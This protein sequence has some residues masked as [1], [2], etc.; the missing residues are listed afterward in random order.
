MPQL[1]V[2][3]R[4][5]RVESLH[6]GYICVSDPDRNIVY[7]IGSPDI[8]CFLRSAGKPIYAVALVDSGAMEKFGLT[9]RDLAMFCSS[10]QG[11]AYQRRIILSI[12]KKIGC[13]ERDLDCGHKYPED[14]EVRDALIMLC[15][16]PTPIFSNCSGKHTG[17]LA[18]CKYYGYPVKGY[19]RPEHPVNLLMLKTMTRLLE[20]DESRIITGTDGCSLPTYMLTIRDIAWLYARLACG[21]GSGHTYDDCL[22]I[23]RD[24]IIQYPDVFRGKGTFC[25][26]L[27]RHT[28]GRV[29][30]KLGAEGLYCMAI[31]E[32]QL[33]VCIKM[34]D[35][36]PWSSFAVAARVLEE[37][38]VLDA[39]TF[40]KL[41]KWTL[42]HIQNDKGEDVGYIHPVF[43]LL[44]QKTGEY[45][46]GCIYP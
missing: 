14:R 35:G 17:F 18:L 8:S 9:F 6:D 10:H 37:L 21:H 20:C 3:T 41:E 32:K 42:P 39:D 15:K 33:G 40:R 27:I 2:R 12:L 13:T 31:P 4:S 11:R 45:E 29:I 7:S 22:G 43:S 36:H 26:E 38:E 25:T 28:K 30:G 16:R 24:A 34:S 5:G 44:E 1:A 19:V 46:P 23:I